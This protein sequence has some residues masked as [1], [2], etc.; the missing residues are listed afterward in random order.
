MKK[1]FY[2]MCV[3][4]FAS[5][6]V[7]TSCNKEEKPE[8]EMSSLKEGTTENGN[9][10]QH[11]FINDTQYVFLF[12]ATLDSNNKCESFLHQIVYVTVALAQEKLP[13]W[14]EEFDDPDNVSI[15]SNVITWDRT[16]SF[17]GKS[18]QDILDFFQNF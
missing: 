8:I 1:F 6:A 10:I 16:A 3:C 15:K 7:M 18:K 2:L 4:L 14:Q 12:T 11:V 13:V 17:K 9:T 5:V